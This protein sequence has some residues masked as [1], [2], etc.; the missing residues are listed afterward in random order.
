MDH[1]MNHNGSEF[2]KQQQGNN[3]AKKGSNV[4][5]TMPEEDEEE[6]L[7][8]YGRL[9]RVKTYRT[10]VSLYHP[11]LKQMVPCAYVKTMTPEDFCGSTMVP[12][13]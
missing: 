8:D 6:M 3:G 4:C 5:P 9:N 2:S 13:Q 1:L 12:G 7:E 11:K 10:D